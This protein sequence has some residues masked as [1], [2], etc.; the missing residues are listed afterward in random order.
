MDIYSPPSSSRV[1][2]AHF[3]SSH[4]PPSTTHII[5]RPLAF[6]AR[7]LGASSRGA[8]KAY[9]KIGTPGRPKRVPEACSARRFLRMIH[10]V[11]LVS[12][13]TRFVSSV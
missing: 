11:A 12:L 8:K 9:K 5:N 13:D 6:S 4:S 10:G 2:A 3:P 1:P 7:E